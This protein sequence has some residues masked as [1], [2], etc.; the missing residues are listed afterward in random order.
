MDNLY[1]MCI[2]V[3]TVSKFLIPKRLFMTI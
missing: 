2:N 1:Q 3:I